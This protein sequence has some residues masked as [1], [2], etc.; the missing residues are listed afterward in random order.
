MDTNKVIPTTP[1]QLD[2]V[3]NCLWYRGHE[4][5]L[6]FTDIA[7]YLNNDLGDAIPFGILL[8]ILKKLHREGY[9]EYDDRAVS[10]DDV[11]TNARVYRLTFD[12]RFWIESGGYHAEAD[13]R[14]AEADRR[15]AE[16]I[17]AERLEKT[18]MALQ[19]WLVALTAILAVGTVVAALWYGT[20]LYWNHGWFHFRK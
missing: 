16:N 14:K 9:I 2:F 4:K 8:P 15:D 19:K 6:T 11:N 10:S 1:K 20:D 18:Q 13:R 12:G 7:E 17:R 5:H 3:L